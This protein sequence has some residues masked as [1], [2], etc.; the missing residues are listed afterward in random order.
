MKETQRKP[1]KIKSTKLTDSQMK[2]LQQFGRVRVKD[3]GKFEKYIPEDPSKPMWKWLLNTT[4]NI[5]LIGDLLHGKGNNVRPFEIGKDELVYLPRFFSTERINSSPGIRDLVLNG[6]LLP[7]NDPGEVPEIDNK[8][9]LETLP[10]GEMKAGDVEGLKD[11]PFIK[12][13]K[14]VRRKEREYNK[15]LIPEGEE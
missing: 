9:V 2:M 11:N 14:E 5:I 8:P 6:D 3:I 15:S 7:V 4:G 12:K 13:L 1:R 10:S